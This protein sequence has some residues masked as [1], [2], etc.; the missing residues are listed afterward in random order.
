VCLT[1]ANEKRDHEFVK[2]KEDMT[3]GRGGKEG[4]KMA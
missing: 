2:E 1:K 4:K 3:G